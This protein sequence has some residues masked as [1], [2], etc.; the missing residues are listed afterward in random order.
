MRKIILSIISALFV[1]SFLFAEKQENLT[2]T[3]RADNG[4]GILCKYKNRKT[5]LFIEGSSEQMGQAH[6]QLLKSDIK[7][8]EETVLVVA[9]GY[10]LTKDDW[11]FTRIQEVINRTT[12]FIPGRFLTECDAMSK[13]AGITADSGRRL[14][15]FPEMFH[16]SGVAVCK[17]ATTNGQVVHARVLDYMKDVN[18]QNYAALMV[19]MPEKYNNWVSV[20][21]AGMLGTVTAM[22]EKGLAMGEMGGRGEGKWDG[23]PMSFM[24]RRVMEE[25]ATVEEAVALMKKTPLTCDYY[26]ILSDKNKSMCGIAAISGSPLEIL[27]PGEQNKLLP[28]VPENCVYISGDERS[29]LLGKRLHDNFGKIDAEK[30]I[31]IIK[32]PVAMN[33]NLHNAVFL[34]ESL[35]FYFSDAGKKDPACFMPYY[36]LNLKELIEFYQENKKQ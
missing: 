24:M 2:V 34:P 17:S 25:C 8:M 10:M 26:Y 21:Y 23:L 28:P 30:M 18:L 33:S 16:C 31:E 4:H 1:C 12:P 35:T 19:F 32:C 5:V 7:S 9:A 15:Y 13:A 20:S 27:K 14:N 6:G 29:K 11:F 3:G 22:N 36:K